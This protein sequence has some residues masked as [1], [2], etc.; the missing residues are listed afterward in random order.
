M[1]QYIPGPSNGSY[2]KTD[3]EYFP[4]ESRV[5]G[6]FATDYAVKTAGLWMLENDFMGGP[7][8]SYSFVDPKNQELITLC[9][10]VYQPNKKKRDLLRQLE[11]IMYSVDFD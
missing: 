11:A 3:Q 10:Y 1:K 4:P 6:D 5:I 2:M 7:F 8:L 9:G